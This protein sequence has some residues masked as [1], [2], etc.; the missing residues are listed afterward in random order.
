MMKKLGLCVLLAVLS[1][2]LLT[3]D[4]K[5]PDSERWLK[6]ACGMTNRQ[7]VI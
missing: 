1:A 3:A 6:Q 5:S 7:P 4:G 2:D